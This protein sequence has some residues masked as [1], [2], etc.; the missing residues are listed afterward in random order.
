MRMRHLARI[1]C[2]H[3]HARRLTHAATHA[4]PLSPQDMRARRA[5][6]AA[7]AEASFL[8]FLG[9]ADPPIPLGASWGFAWEEARARLG[10]DPR[11]GLVPDA[12]RR[13]EVFDAFMEDAEAVGAGHEI[14]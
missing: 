4:R 2:T 9:A 11:W 8:D 13:R 6:E 7:A 10:G 14:R 12:A 1:S 3:S 5:A